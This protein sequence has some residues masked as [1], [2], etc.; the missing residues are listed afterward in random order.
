MLDRCAVYRLPLPSGGVVRVRKLN[1]TTL[2]GHGLL[3]FPL[4][5]AAIEAGRDD[6]DAPVP[7]TWKQLI[8]LCRAALMDGTID[9]ADLSVT[10][11]LAI[12]QW[13]STARVIE[14]AIP[15][16]EQPFAAAD[17]MELVRSPTAVTIETLCRRYTM[18]PSTLMGIEDDDLAADLDMALAYRGLR[19]DSDQADGSG[20]IEV[21]DVYGNTHKVPASWF[22]TSVEPGTKVVHVD[23]YA[24]RAAR[25]GL[26]EMALS[27]G[28]AI[29]ASPG[30]TIGPMGRFRG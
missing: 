22:D 17:F 24:K 7:Q 13:A 20:E 18:R 6:E 5:A 26:R 16:G 28:G 25:L 14:P 27:A 19:Q 29:G 21:E 15:D 9:P 10:D 4:L 1:R 8:A 11:R 23:Q 30:D 12:Y 3:A 2:L